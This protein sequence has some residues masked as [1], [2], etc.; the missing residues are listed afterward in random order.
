MIFSSIIDL[1][2]P[3]LDPEVWDQRTGKLIEAHKKDIL[4]ILETKLNAKGWSHF[5]DWIVAKRIIGSST[6]YLWSNTADIDA[7]F[8]VDINEFIDKEL[9]NKV[10]EQEAADMLDEFRKEM[11][12]DEYLLDDTFHPIE[13]YFEIPG[14]KEAEKIDSGEYDLETDEWVKEP[15]IVS[16]DYD[17]EEVYKAIMPE[18]ETILQEFDIDAGKIRREIDQIKMIEETIAAWDQD[19]KQRFQ[20]KLEDKLSQLEKDIKQLIDSGEKIHDRRKQEYKQQ[21]LGIGNL[22]FKYLQRFGYVYLWTKLKELLMNDD[23]ITQDEIED[24]QEIVK[25][26]PGRRSYMSLEKE[27]KI[28]AIQDMIEKLAEPGNEMFAVD[29]EVLGLVNELGEG[30]VMVE[31]LEKKDG[32]AKVKLAEEPPALEGQVYTIDLQHL[33]QANLNAI[34]KVLF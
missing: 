17:A 33:K 18:I 1:P 16:E 27:I 10:S 2:K 34:V 24:V 22:A 7:H 14:Y 20:K 19:K 9:D 32:K 25:D 29:T 8:V 21:D 30:E 26:Y 5:N 3:G 15:W 13:F 31:L 12:K 4:H 28:R 6:T 23:K 11:N